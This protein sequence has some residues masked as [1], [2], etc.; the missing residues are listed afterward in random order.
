MNKRLALDVEK[1]VSEGIFKIH[2]NNDCIDDLICELPGVKDTPYEGGIWS[3]S[4]KITDRYPF[5]PPQVKF[6]TKIW[7]PNVSSKTG[8][9]CLDILNNNWSPIINIQTILMS[10]Q[11]FMQSPNF[12]DP[13]DGVVAKQERSMFTE[14]AKFWTKIFAN[15]SKDFTETGLLYYEQILLAIQNTDK[16]F[17]DLVVEFSNNNWNMLL[18]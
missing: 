8:L 18:I 2:L 17:E 1:V 10:L 12:D 9:I 14:T 13:Q 15:S 11:L 16:S 5:K 4:I 3:I 7:H 6:I